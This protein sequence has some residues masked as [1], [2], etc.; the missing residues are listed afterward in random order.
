MRSQ[1]NLKFCL[2]VCCFYL[3]NN[4]LN[5]QDKDTTLRH[6]IGFSTSFSS[7][8]LS[9]KLEGKAIFNQQTFDFYLENTSLGAGNNYQLFYLYNLDSSDFYILSEVGVLVGKKNMLTGPESGSS[10]QT[11]MSID[12]RMWHFAAMIGYKIKLPKQLSL[13]LSTGILA[14][15]YNKLTENFIYTDQS[16]Q[17]NITKTYFTRFFP[18]FIGNAAL[19]YTYNKNLSFSI[20]SRLTLLTLQEKRSKITSFSSTE[21]E[22]ITTYYPNISDQETTYY[23]DLSSLKNDPLITPNNFDSNKPQGALSKNLPYSNIAFGIKFLWSF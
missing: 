1:S 16:Y 14:P 18:G 7:A 15:L 4:S 12:T 8:A 11:G 3:L 10:I 6:Q 23:K 9:N 17:A 22:Q 20:F 21:N 19:N 2:L 13:S 5:G